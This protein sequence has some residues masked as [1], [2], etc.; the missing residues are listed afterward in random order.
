[1][2]AQDATSQPTPRRNAVGAL[3]CRV[4]APLAAILPRNAASRSARYSAIT[5]RLRIMRH[6]LR[7]WFG[8]PIAERRQ[9]DIDPSVWRP[10]FDARYGRLAPATKRIV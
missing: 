4:I 3:M 1:M 5:R 8:A 2:E 7:R 6:R 10:G 9:R